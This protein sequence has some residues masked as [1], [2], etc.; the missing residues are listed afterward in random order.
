MT[1]EEMLPREIKF[2][3]IHCSATR[4]NASF[5]VDQ[6]RQCHL[7]RGFNDIGYHIYITR[8]G[9]VH[10]T[11]PLEQQGAHAKGFN[12]HSVGICYEGGLDESGNPADTRTNAQRVALKDVLTLLKQVYPAARIVG[13][14]QL[15]ADVHKA[16]PCFDARKEYSF[17]GAQ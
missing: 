7:Q 2:L 13:H 15:T 14:Y 1:D 5:T 12:R 17:I 3:V 10:H 16:C 11:R 8:D 4:C 9:L 6:L